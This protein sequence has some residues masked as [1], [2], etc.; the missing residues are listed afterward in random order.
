MTQKRI[1]TA[2][3]MVLLIGLAAR[4]T[5]QTPSAWSFDDFKGLSG[6][7]VI[8][9]PVDEDAE[10]D[11]LTRAAIQTSVEATLRLADIRVLAQAEGAKTLGKPVLGVS[12]DTLA[13]NG[14]YVYNIRVELR[15]TV[16]SLVRPGVAYDATTWN[17]GKFGTV[18]AANVRELHDA[19]NDFVDEFVNDWLTANPKRP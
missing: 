4:T 11:G 6:V 7:Q 14:F 10:R 18:D 15:Q 9:A 19:V 8:V 17:R 2:V 16:Q 12:V 3:F 5:A 13:S 1:A